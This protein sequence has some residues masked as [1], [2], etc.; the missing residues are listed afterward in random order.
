MQSDTETEGERETAR[1]KEEE[2]RQ[3]ETETDTEINGGRQRETGTEGLGGRYAGWHR[4]RERKIETARQNETNR[5]RQNK[6]ILTNRKTER[7]R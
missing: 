7:G 4:Y 5:E 3:R 2:D 1:R 6:N